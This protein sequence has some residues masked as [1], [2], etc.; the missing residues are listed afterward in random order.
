MKLR[1]P[2]TYEEGLD[3]FFADLR[4]V[5][6]YKHRTY[7]P[8][9]LLRYS[10]YDILQRIGD[11]TARAEGQILWESQN[12]NWFRRTWRR[13]QQLL[14]I[15]SEEGLDDTITDIAGYASQWW[16]KRRGWLDLP[17]EK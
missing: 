9:N 3:L 1:R 11:K 17:M 13:L 8:T 16:L 15:R 6:L 12:R 7:G 2:A 4:E 10:E 5:L 14:G